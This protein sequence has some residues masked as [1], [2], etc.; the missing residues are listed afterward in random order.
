MKSKMLT[1]RV[2]ALE[3]ANAMLE[4]QVNSDAL[5]GLLNRRGLENVLARELS[6]AHRTGNPL[7]AALVDLDDFKSFNDMYG[8]HVGDEVLKFVA[9]SLTDR[10]RGCDWS[11]RVGGDEFLVLLPSTSL[12]QGISVLERIR[13][14]IN[15]RTIVAGADLFLHTSISIGLAQIDEEVSTTEDVLRV[16][17]SLLKAS[18]RAGKN[19]ISIKTYRSEETQT[20]SN[21]VDSYLES[22]EILVSARASRSE[23][24]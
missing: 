5:T 4:S 15:E 14:G 1:A 10:I 8:H 20:L 9:Q 18:K 13:L 22:G 7:L 12:K 23:K 16:T 17:T 3:Q 19:R 24:C 2:E 21:G 11:S 6:F